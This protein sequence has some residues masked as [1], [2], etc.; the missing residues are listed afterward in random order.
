VPACS[1]LEQGKLEQAKAHLEKAI[2]AGETARA[3]HVCAYTLLYE[4]HHFEEALRRRRTSFERHQI[5][6]ADPAIRAHHAASG[7]S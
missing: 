3:R 1:E 7:Y 4:D 5:G 6:R 2:E